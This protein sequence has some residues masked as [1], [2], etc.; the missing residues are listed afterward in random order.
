MAATRSRS[1]IAAGARAARRGVSL[2][3]VLVMLVPGLLLLGVAIYAYSRMERQGAW[4]SSRLGAVDRAVTTLETV[5][6]DVAA[7]QTG[8]V[9]PDGDSLKLEAVRRGA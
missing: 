9:E 3:E 6:T 2:M 5:R 1:A 7:A 4:N 8:A